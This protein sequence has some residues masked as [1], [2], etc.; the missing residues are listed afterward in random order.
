M[1]I[2]SFCCFGRKR[3]IKQKPQVENFYSELE[4]RELEC[5]EECLEDC[6][7]EC[8]EDCRELEC[9]D[10]CREDCCEESII[11]IRDDL[12]ISNNEIVVF[13]CMSIIVRPMNSGTLI[14]SI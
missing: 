10:E 7:E 13:D 9:Q 3:K 4:C 12:K 8:L 1:D 2:F 14:F 6:R 11:D 5:R